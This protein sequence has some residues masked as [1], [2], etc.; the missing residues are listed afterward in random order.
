MDDRCPHCGGRAEFSASTSGED[1]LPVAGDPSICLGC[2]SI[3]VFDKEMKLR[4]P[5]KE[6]FD[7]FISFPH[8][9][10]A[11]MSVARRNRRN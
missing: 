4:A 9:Q 6:E 1:V 10:E 11:I 5:T 7:H 2:A 8:I 3:S